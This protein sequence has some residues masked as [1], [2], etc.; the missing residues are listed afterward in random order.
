MLTYNELLSQVK[1]L[2]PEERL[3]L[4][5][6]TTQMLKEDLQAQRLKELPLMGHPTRSVVLKSIQELQG[7]LN[8]QDRQY[9]DEELADLK[10]SYLAEKYGLKLADG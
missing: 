8:P 7:S 9:S 6:A 2:T 5:E 1:Q 3:A 10:Y 4:I